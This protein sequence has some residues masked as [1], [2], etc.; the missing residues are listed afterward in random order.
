MAAIPFP[1]DGLSEVLRPLGFGEAVLLHQ[2]R[3][4]G[5][6]QLRLRSAGSVNPS[7][8]ITLKRSGCRPTSLLGQSRQVRRRGS[9]PRVDLHAVPQALGQSFLVFAGTQ[10]E[11]QPVQPQPQP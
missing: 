3:G 2:Q 11:P 6:P 10:G 5:D 7:A 8:D 4:D 9:Q 1:A